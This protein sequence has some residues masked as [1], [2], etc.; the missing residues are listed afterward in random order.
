MTKPKT[1]R[2]PRIVKAWLRSGAG[3]H[4]DHRDHDATWK[5]D[6]AAGGYEDMSYSIYI[7]NV[8]KDDGDDIVDGDSPG[9]FDHIKARL[10]WAKYWINWALDNCEKPGVWNF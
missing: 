6:V 4:K 1:P 5:A 2:D 10:I 7:G 8:V 3:P 9:D